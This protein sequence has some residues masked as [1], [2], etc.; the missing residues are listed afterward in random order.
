M[1]C[2]SQRWRFTLMGRFKPGLLARLRLALP[3]TRPN[4]RT[5][6]TRLPQ[7]VTTVVATW[8]THQPRPSRSRINRGLILRACHLFPEE[9]ILS[10][11][12]NL[13][14]AQTSA[15]PHAFL[16]KTAGDQEKAEHK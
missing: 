6:R 3:V 1:E 8:R 15:D 13:W 5:D 4:C 12:G 11:K 16:N 9:Q 7:R 10:D 2:P 14:A